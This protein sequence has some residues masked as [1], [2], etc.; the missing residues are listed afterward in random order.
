MPCMISVDPI[1]TRRG[2]TTI[3]ETQHGELYIN[4]QRTL[5]HLCSLFNNPTDPI[6]RDHVK[7]YLQSQGI[8]TREDS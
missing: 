3:I 8:D 1:I 5:M 7:L 4:A 6:V 2:T